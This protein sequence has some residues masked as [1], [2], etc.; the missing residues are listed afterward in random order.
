MEFIFSMYH[1]LN[2]QGAFSGILDRIGKAGSFLNSS[3]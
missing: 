3:S 2:K 1:N